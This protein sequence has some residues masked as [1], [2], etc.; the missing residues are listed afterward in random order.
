M[1]AR[2]AQKTENFGR[3]GKR[4]I[5]SD[6]W[7]QF[8]EKRLLRTV[9]IAVKAKLFDIYVK[10]IFDELLTFQKIGHNLTSDW[11]L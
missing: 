2:H 4:E 6:F 7:D 9:K 8:C 1:Q 5:T 11:N 10:Y 3:L